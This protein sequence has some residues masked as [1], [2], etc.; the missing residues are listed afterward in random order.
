MIR[1]LEK[2]EMY[3]VSGKVFASV[4]GD[5]GLELTDLQEEQLIAVHTR[6]VD[7]DTVS[8]SGQPVTPEEIAG[9]I[10]VEERDQIVTILAEL[11]AASHGTVTATTVPQFLDYRALEA[12]ACV[13]LLR[14]DLCLPSSRQW[15]K[16][17]HMAIAGIM[18]DTACDA[19]DDKREGKLQFSAG[20][21]A[22]G[23]LKRFAIHSHKMGLDTIRSLTRHSYQEGLIGH[24][25]GKPVR[26]IRNIRIATQAEVA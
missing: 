23:A 17:G 1:T 10:G 24:M 5:L 25:A 18:L 16:L 4:C 22:C 20:T 3:G 2:R 14:A 6:L 19:L 7:Y 26:I 11:L 9:M 15:D 12:L 13:D 8:E 21:V